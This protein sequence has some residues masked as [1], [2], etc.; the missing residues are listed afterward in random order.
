MISG[1][2]E[3]LEKKSPENRVALITGSGKGVGA[4]IIRVFTKAGIRCCINC[5]T[6]RTMADELLKEVESYGGEAFIYQADVT[7]PAM[8]KGMVDAVLEHYGRLDILVNNAAMQPNR[9]IDGYDEETFRW[10]WNINIGGYFHMVRECLPYLKESPEGRIIN[11]S[12]VHGKRPTSFDAG[13][14]TT[15]GAIRMFTRELA[16]ELL[17]TGITVN[18]IDL[19]GCKIEFKTGNAKWV[20]Y[21]PME[22]NNPT[23]KRVDLQVLPTE[24]GDVVY[25]LCSKEGKAINGHAVRVDNGLLLT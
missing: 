24:V 21:H 7:D 25:F 22:I 15:K 12:S 19:G 4:G 8:R 1:S 9:F 2:S 17:P 3:S 5:N 16:L 10:L 11:I 6:N 13:Y 23:M 18:A 20:T 14:A